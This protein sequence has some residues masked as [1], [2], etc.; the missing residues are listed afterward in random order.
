MFSLENNMADNEIRVWGVHTLDDDLFLKKNIIAIGWDEMGDLSKIEPSRE[1]FKEYY[2]NI[3]KD[4][5]PM[6]VAVSAAIVYRFIHE[7]KKGDYVVYPSK[8]DRMVNIGV[9]TGDY[10]HCKD[11][12]KYTQQRSVKWEKHIPRINFSQG[13][14]YEIG[15]FMSVFSIKNFADEFISLVHNAYDVK[16]ERVYIDELR[17]QIVNF[18]RDYI[19]KSLNKHLKGYE[20]ENFVANLLNAMGYKTKVSK[21]GGDSGID[22]VAYKDELPPRIVVQVKS[23]YEQVKETTIQSLKGAMSDGDYGLFV[24]L[25]DY[26]KNAKNFLKANPKI[27]GIDGVELVDLILKYYEDLSEEY[28]RIIPLKK[29]YIPTIND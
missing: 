12:D 7:I 10:E 5:S 23:K 18:T 13:A 2:S 9:V 29:V 16:I 21:Q 3:Y 22:I 24:T 26:S 19:I 14:L 28:K 11:R 4:A 17:E 20:M 25:S 8:K 6:S 1:A 15:S 27:R